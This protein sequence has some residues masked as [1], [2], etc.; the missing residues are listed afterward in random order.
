MAVVS[1]RDLTSGLVPECRTA[2]D[3]AAEPIQQR[4]A[5]LYGQQLLSP[6]TTRDEVH[7]F[8]SGLSQPE[9]QSLRGGIRAKIAETLS[10][11]KRSAADPNTDAKQGIAALRDL[12]SDAARQKLSAVMGQGE[13]SSMFG[14]IDRAS[15]AFEIRAG[16]Q[17][18]RSQRAE[19]CRSKPVRSQRWWQR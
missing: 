4:E 3:T 18:P 13:A 9:L 17:R 8:V 16:R 10:N 1:I 6:G 2:L 14:A 19:Q 12:S 5:M 7:E 15:R 11:I